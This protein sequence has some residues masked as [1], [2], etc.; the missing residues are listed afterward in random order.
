MPLFYRLYHPANRSAL[1]A[2]ALTLS[3]V[4]D[5]EGGTVQDVV[6]RHLCFPPP[7]PAL[8]SQ[9]DFQSIFSCIDLVQGSCQ[10]KRHFA[11]HP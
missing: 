6:R 7:V 8:S 10:W 3:R 5:P 9:S 4:L 11:W 1:R 2:Q